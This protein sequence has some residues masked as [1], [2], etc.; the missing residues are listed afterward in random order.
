MYPTENGL[1]LGDIQYLEIITNVPN[2][3]EAGQYDLEI[4]LISEEA[5]QSETDSE[6]THLRELITIAITVREFH[7]MQIM[8]DET[9]ENT[10]K[11]AAPG[12]TVQYLV[13]VT[14]N[15]N[16][17]DDA[18]LNVH[19][20]NNDAWNEDPGFGILTSWVIRWSELENFGSEV[21]TQKECLETST[22]SGATEAGR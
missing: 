6:E 17:V 11:I 16:V 5:Y 9:L 7:D 1:Q 4:G 10:V 12:R 8:I 19:T 3:V 13:N 18:F 14:N 2:Q 21:P 20:M 22:V 15:G